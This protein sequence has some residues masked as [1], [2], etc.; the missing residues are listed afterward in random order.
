[1]DR[2]LGCPDWREHFYRVVSTTN[3]FGETSTDRIKEADTKKFEQF[4]LDRLRTIFTAVAPESVPL[5][6]S[7][8]QVMYL[9][10]FAC[11]N[12]K[13]AEIA[14]RIARHLIRGSIM[15]KKNKR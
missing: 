8:G 11:G 10:C 2:F 15:K 6:N 3:L 13:G 14:V 1:L 7:R 12:Q 9:L 5:K 4:F